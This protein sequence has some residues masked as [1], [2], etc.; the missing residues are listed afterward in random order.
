[1]DKKIIESW[2]DF[3]SLNKS[4]SYDV[5]EKYKIFKENFKKLPKKDLVKLKWI[6]STEDMSS[7]SYFFKD[8]IK[9]DNSSSLF[10]KSITSDNLLINLW[11]S[12]VKSKAQLSILLNDTPKYE[13]IDKKFLKEVALLSPD[14]NNIKKIPEILAKSG[15]ILI[16]E[17]YIPSMKLDGCVFLLES[18]NPVIAM[19]LRYSRLDNYWFTLM[20]ELAH[21]VLHNEL[22]EQ[23]IV[24]NFEEETQDKV[25]LQANKLAKESFVS[26]DKWRNCPAKYS[27]D[28]NV[29]IE[30]SESIGINPIIIAGLLRHEE[31]NY[32]L[33]SK[34]IRSIDVKE[35]I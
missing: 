30:F 7:L 13:S 25:E 15:I 28:I 9:S 4:S 12:K 11:L 32:S 33:H 29:L 6:S 1:M 26:R 8:F 3:D 19:S 18:G 5:F 20:H 10:R 17:D 2:F 27:K 14:P 16:Y 21:I 22:L 24:D 34:L 23:G 31:N 35:I